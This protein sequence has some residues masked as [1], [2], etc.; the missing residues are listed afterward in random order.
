MARH[1][2]AMEP[3]GDLKAVEI[4]D[5]DQARELA[6]ELGADPA[7]LQAAINDRAT[8][9]CWSLD[10]EDTKRPKRIRAELDRLSDALGAAMATI[11]QL[12]ERARSAVDG[13]LIEMLGGDERVSTRAYEE[14]QKKAWTEG[15]SY[16]QSL[17][18]RIHEAAGR[19]KESLPRGDGRE[20]LGTL[21]W[22]CDQLDGIYRRHSTA[23]RK[24][25]KVVLPWVGRVVKMIDPEVTDSNLR[26]ALRD[27]R[28]P[29]QK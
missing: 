5:L 9:Y 7:R 28:K 11:D 20:G 17:M 8:V 16:T 13:A 1:A 6:A 21:R 14:A 2:V 22:L 25:L 26:T 24:P 15:I 18:A 12:D 23:K 29:P 19:A 27:I 3:T 4:V 10:S